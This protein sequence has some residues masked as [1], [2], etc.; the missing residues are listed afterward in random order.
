MRCAW[1]LLCFL[2]IANQQTIAQDPSPPES[3]AYFIPELEHLLEEETADHDESILLEALTDLAEKPVDLNSASFDDLQRVPGI[4]PVLAYRIIARRAQRS[5][6]HKKDLMGVDGITEELFIAIRSF[7]SLGHDTPERKMDLRMRL[8]IQSDLQR[9]RGY[10]EKAYSGSR[11]R[12]YQRTSFSSDRETFGVRQVSG[13]MVLEKDAGERW[14]SGHAAGYVRM[15]IPVVSTDL[16]FG[17]YS[18]ASGRGL[19][20]GAPGLRTVP[21]HRVFTTGSGLR[22]Y[23]STTED[24]FFRGLAFE[25]VGEQIRIVGFYSNRPV[26]ASVSD[27]GQITRFDASG[28]FRTAQ[29]QRTRFAS[30]ERVAGGVITVVPLEHIRVS[31]KGYEA[32]FTTPLRLAQQRNFHGDRSSTI[33]VDLVYAHSKRSLFFEVAGDRMGSTAFLIGGQEHV[34]GNVVV[35]ISGRWFPESFNNRYGTRLTGNGIP[36]NEHGLSVSVIF[37]VS[38]RLRVTGIYDFSSSPRGSGGI[39]FP[40]Q[41]DD[42]LILSEFKLGRGIGMDLQ[43]REKSK[44]I[45]KTRNDWLGRASSGTGL[46]NQRNFRF[47][48]RFPRRKRYFMRSRFEYTAVRSGGAVAESGV[49]LSQFIRLMPLPSIEIEGRFTMFETDS[50]DSRLYEY[51]QD[52]PGTFSNPALFGRGIKASLLVSAALSASLELF[53]KYGVTVKEGAKSTGSGLEVTPGD[54]RN[55]VAIQIDVRL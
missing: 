7:V 50:Y 11:P 46:R 34:A 55:R 41:R 3:L 10:A 19:A 31:L 2:P 24:L 52:V 44:T 17:D 45:Q 1:I 4:T 12:L 39:V 13:M 6:A 22:G 54:F 20:L 33:G 35:G 27:E 37:P 42:I 36:E 51:E 18:I 9:S 38:S 49:L 26:H 47:T 32:G 21:P 40:T 43:F 14:Q 53:V 29:E 16:L 28:L 15:N 23:A 5:F 25:T 30:R 8:R 48:L